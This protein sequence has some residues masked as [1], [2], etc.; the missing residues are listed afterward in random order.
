[1]I[2]RTLVAV[3]LSLLFLPGAVHANEGVMFSYVLE[4]RRAADDVTTSEFGFLIHFDKEASADIGGTARLDVIAHDA[5]D[6]VRVELS[7]N[8]YV[9][10]EIH[11]VGSKAVTIPYGSTRTVSWDTPDLGSYSLSVSPVRH[12]FQ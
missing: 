1:M 4:E 5:G 11:P 6:S 8:D 9:G 7:L 10:E 12:P 2:A 3:S